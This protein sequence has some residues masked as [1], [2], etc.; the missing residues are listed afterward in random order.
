MNRT[1]FIKHSLLVL[2]GFLVVFIMLYFWLK[3]KSG[4]DIALV[5]FSV[6][7]LVVYTL[8]IG[9]V[10]YSWEL[11]AKYGLISGLLTSYFLAYILFKVF[12]Y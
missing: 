3:G 10:T 8:I 7:F 1:K 9:L 5:M 11:N 2:F 6:I 4:G 12:I